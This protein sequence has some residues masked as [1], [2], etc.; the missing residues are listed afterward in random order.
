M[1][2]RRCTTA[3]PADLRVRYT[4]LGMETRR[5]RVHGGWDTAMETGQGRFGVVVWGK[6]C[7]LCVLLA[8]LSSQ[9]SLITGIEYFNS[10]SFLACLVVAVTLASMVRL[11][12]HAAVRAAASCMVL[13]LALV[14]LGFMVYLQGVG[15][16]DVAPAVW[17]GYAFL[18]RTATL[19]LNVE[20]NYQY[21]LNDAA[22]SPRCVCAAVLLALALF[23]TVVALGGF[24][25]QVVL[26]ACLLVSSLLAVWIIRSEMLGLTGSHSA[27]K[28]VEADSEHP[29][30]DESHGP[31]R[32]L[33]FGS[34][35]LYG[36]AL[37]VIVSLASWSGSNAA[38]RPVLAISAVC[39][40]LIC[41]G[42]TVGRM[43]MARGELAATVLLPLVASLLVLI[44]FYYEGQPWGLC[45]AALLAEVAWTTQ[46][47]FQ[48]PSYRRICDM[49]PASFAVADY[50]AQMVAYYPLVWLLTSSGALPG[51]LEARGVASVGFGTVCYALLGL[52]CMIAMARHTLRYLPAGML[53][54]CAPAHGTMAGH[55]LGHGARS[56]ALGMDYAAGAAQN[57]QSAGGE[58]S[59]AGSDAFEALTPRERDVMALMAAGYSRSYIGKVLYISPDTVKVHAKHIY[60]KLGIS[61]KDELIELVRRADEDG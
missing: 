49:H 37:G 35:L 13:I 39:L 15:R 31:I 21:A 20:W 26:M 27:E 10:E 16:G 58:K 22:E 56:E 48:L 3:L 32:F 61:S 46:N 38:P 23:L 55:A 28:V 42:L 60:A 19:L 1:G 50:A 5:G 34:R 18:G 54:G 45:Q 57:A 36:C 7:A 24:A 51:Y 47:L 29:V 9:L 30:A 44:A 53:A 17:V 41:L 25:A 40:A 59:A 2:V 52:C 6:A 8:S 4:G 43:F 33:Y 12:R 14:W 11:L